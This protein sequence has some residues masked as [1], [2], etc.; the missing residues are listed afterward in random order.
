MNELDLFAAAIGIADPAE[1]EA[2][3]NRECAGQGDLRRRLD[4]LL[5]AH[6]RSNS[7]FDKHRPDDPNATVSQP[8]PSL[9]V[10]TVVA[11]R[12]KLLEEIGD[13]GMGTVWMA[14]QKEPVKRL[15]AVKLIKAGMDS[16][17]VLARFEAERQALALMDHPNIAKVHDAGTDDQGRPYFVMELVKGLPL[18]EYCD[19]RKLSVNERLDLFVQI[20]SAVQ[21]AHQKA[22]IHRDLKPTN[23]LVTE[24]DGKPVPKVI[25]FGL[26]KALNSSQ[27]LTDRT[28]HTAYGAVVGT[29]LYM[30]PE[31]VGI[32]ALDVDT[33]TDIYALGVILYELLTGTTPLERAKLKEAAWEEMKRLIR[34]EEP[35]R[36]STRLSS[37][38]NLPS[39]AASRRIE[40]AQLSRLVRGELDWI[41]MKALEKDRTR[42]YETANGLAKDVQ[43]YLAGDAVEACP[44]TLGYLVRK[45][46]RRNKAAV[47]VGGAFA[48]VLLAAT[49]VSLTFGVVAK[50]AEGEAEARRQDAD[51]NAVR[52]DEN[53]RQAQANEEHAQ[54]EA[55]NVKAEQ[56]RTR[57][58]FYAS[59]LASASFALT[60][61]RGENVLQALAATTPKP[62]ESDLRGW[63]WHYL[64]RLYSPTV[65]DL[66]LGPPLPEDW[67]QIAKTTLG[68]RPVVTRFDGQRLWF[69]VFDAATGKQLHRIPKEGTLQEWEPLPDR[70][71]GLEP[72][73]GFVR[74]AFPKSQETDS[75]PEGVL[76][77]S[78][79]FLAARWAVKREP[80]MTTDRIRLWRLDTGEELPD[81]PEKADAN[82]WAL[83]L[84]PNAEWVAWMQV[85]DHNSTFGEG[86]SKEYPVTFHRW[87]R[88]A[89]RLTS[90]TFTTVIGAGLRIT[91]DGNKVC[92]TGR[93]GNPG[94]Q[95]NAITGERRN[96]DSYKCWDVTTDP[97]KLH[98]IP[99]PK[100]QIGF[101]TISAN[102][103]FVAVWDRNEVDRNEVVVR[104]LPDGKELWRHAFGRSDE[105]KGTSDVLG[106]PAGIS[107]DGRRVV[108]ATRLMLRVIEHPGPAKS[109]S[110][111]EWTFRH[112]Y[113]PFRQRAPGRDVQESLSA[114]IYQ[115]LQG[116]LSPDGRT[117]Y[118]HLPAMGPR[119]LA[120]DLSADPQSAG[121]GPR[122]QRVVVRLGA[123]EWSVRDAD[124]KEIARVT[125]RV[126]T[127]TVKDR[128]VVGMPP[129]LGRD[130]PGPPEKWE[131]FDI[132]DPK[133]IR[134]VASDVGLA[135]VTDDGRW[136]VGNNREYLPFGGRRM[137]AV[138]WTTT[139]VRSLERGQ[140]VGRID[141]PNGTVFR[142]SETKPDVDLF[143]AVTIATP[144]PLQPSDLQTLGSVGL[145][146]KPV[147]HTLRLYEIGT[148][149]E[150][151]AK[152]IGTANFASPTI[153][154]DRKRIFTVTSEGSEVGD[155]GRVWVHNVADGSLEQSF[156][157]PFRVSSRDPLAGE[158]SD[159]QLIF[160]ALNEIQIWDPT[161]GTR[162]HRLT[163]NDALRSRVACSPDGRRLFVLAGRMRGNASRLHVWD[164][165]TGREVLNMP[166][167]FADNDDPRILRSLEFADGKLR[168]SSANDVR[169]LDGTPLPEP[170]K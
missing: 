61:G 134:L 114:G 73:E 14:E 121:P 20:C 32:N 4:L 126:L 168:Y 3:L 44:P 15:V 33:R 141:A 66:Q 147:L 156:F 154:R 34:E 127:R 56:D 166:L 65:H 50:R 103:A 98:T 96:L 169:I 53:A 89:K 132:T 105:G 25:D 153:S 131:C 146:R 150:R 157:V 11:G 140:M 71:K 107:D 108:F 60:E 90:R 52:A 162:T 143:A 40:P 77:D 30:A 10:G 123:F 27:M 8:P 159:G 41:V 161:T 68:P 104:S 2:L 99:L 28:L 138:Y 48:A 6:G 16:K 130:E 155:R 19:A 128:W 151:W 112:R 24:H 119:V 67:S 135:F 109:G 75:L 62:G 117:F 45:A 43:R 37:T 93:I 35:P 110:A 51:A 69:E 124:G 64:N 111:R 23:V 54:R 165:T 160:A 101:L 58:L 94:L 152:E 9:L 31:Q 17:A 164:L 18:T 149:R 115:L 82:V 85:P 122:P 36:P 55:A 79:R 70:Y 87:D 21:H 83:T 170:A 39:L 125:N 49:A 7:L 129:P 148:G 92:M 142:A 29:P 158:T 95:F 91:P 46:Y 133:G 63:E 38:A 145:T 136:V 81:A 118:H 120:F 5:E 78:A 163:G 74:V 144:P 22:I 12:Y 97:P 1:R 102:S 106:S 72:Q 84:G 59:E 26:A 137:P 57:R 47:L 76:D 88:A 80:G 167:R 113:V 86:L 42:R 13:G 139:T 100:G 116:K